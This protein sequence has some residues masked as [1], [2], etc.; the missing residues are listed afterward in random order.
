V[1]PASSLTLACL[2]VG[3]SVGPA[4]SAQQRQPGPVERISEDL[5]ERGQFA[6]AL[7]AGQTALDAARRA[8]D[9][10]R[11]AAALSSLGNA[12]F[13]LGDRPRA[14]DFFQLALAKARELGD[15]T[16]EATELKN[17]GIAYQNLARPEESLEFFQQALRISRRLNDTALIASS[18]ENLGMAHALLGA[19]RQA[20]DFFEQTREIAEDHALRDQQHHVLVDMGRLLLDLRQPDQARARFEQALAVAE[21]EN[22]FVGQAYALEGL[23]LAYAALGD[24]PNAIATAHRCLALSSSVQH[25]GPSRNACGTSAPITWSPIPSVH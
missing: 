19:H 11:E 18:L 20:F 16:G 1:S 12:Y 10:R 8:G 25:A 24:M 23:S 9:A 7:R 5:L 14:L 13:F 21:Q 4:A 15:E 17:I 3:A 2:L 6:D 22:H